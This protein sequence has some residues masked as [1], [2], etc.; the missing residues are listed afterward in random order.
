MT[1]KDYINAKLEFC[2][3]AISGFMGGLFLMTIGMFTIEEVAAKFS[4]AAFAFCCIVGI[5]GYT[6]KYSDFSNELNDLS[7]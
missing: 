1:K 4:S 5:L 7:D 3:L 2:K 6:K